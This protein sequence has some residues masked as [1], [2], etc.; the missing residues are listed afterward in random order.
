MKLKGSNRVRAGFTITEVALGIALLAVFMGATGIAALRSADAFSAARRVDELQSET[1]RVMT[2]VTGELVGTGTGVL[3]P[4]PDTDW[5]TGV[6]GFRYPIGFN[7]G[8]V[9]W[10]NLQ[11]I[12]FEYAAGEIDDGAD[13]NGDGLVDEGQI[14]LVRDVGLAS[15]RRVVIC[16]NVAELGEGEIVNNLDDNGNGVRDEAGFNVQRVGDVLTVRVTLQG[17]GETGVL[18][19]RSMSGSV[20]LRN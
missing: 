18:M 6:F 13:N 5:G 11:T 15:Q 9:T 10:G 1:A 7:A 8:A 20:R 12:G 17:I 2:R 3:A 16:S 14:V 19:E 4:D